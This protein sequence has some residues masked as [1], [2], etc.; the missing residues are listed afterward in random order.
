[1]A[2]PISE[3]PTSDVTPEL[4]ADGPSDQDGSQYKEARKSQK[5]I[6]IVTF[7][8][9][10][11]ILCT[12]AVLVAILLIRCWEKESNFK[13]TTMWPESGQCKGPKEKPKGNSFLIQ[14]TI[15]MK[16]GECLCSASES[17]FFLFECCSAL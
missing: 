17:D 1:M 12:V 7:V 10:G 6:R 15:D 9:V 11:M 4:P 8:G 16:K 5:T 2:T 3:G 14:Q 13:R